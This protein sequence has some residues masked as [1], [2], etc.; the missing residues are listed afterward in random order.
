VLG[1]SALNYLA[2]FLQHFVLGPILT[3]LDRA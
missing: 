1:I 2:V 3:W